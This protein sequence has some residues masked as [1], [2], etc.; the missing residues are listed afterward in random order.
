M[1]KFND[2]MKKVVVDHD[3]LCHKP[4]CTIEVDGR[5]VEPCMAL[6]Q[7]ERLQGTTFL[8]LTEAGLGGLCRWQELQ[9]SKA[10]ENWREA[11]SPSCKTTGGI[12]VV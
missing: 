3:K 5:F 10:V 8:W 2:C 4:T 12:L 9:F 11:V 1:S 7:E 6:R